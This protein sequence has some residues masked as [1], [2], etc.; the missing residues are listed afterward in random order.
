MNTHHVLAPL[1]A[2]ALAAACCAEPAPHP[3]TA[4]THTELPHAHDPPPVHSATP[5]PTATLGGCRL[6]APK[7]SQDACKTDA[8]CGPSEPCHAPECVARARSKPPTPD[9]VCTQSLEC[10]T[11]DMNHCGCHQGHCALIPGR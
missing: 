7:V 1:A 10:G 6:P 2:L 9:T 4:P 5:A 8:D 11:T 3:G